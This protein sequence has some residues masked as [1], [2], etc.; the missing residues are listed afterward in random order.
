MIDPDFAALVD[1]KD[2]HVF[3]TPYE[4]DHLLYVTDVT[5]EGFTVRTDMAFEAVKGRQE[6]ELSGAFSWRVVARRK[7]IEGKRLEKVSIP[8]EPKLPS[9]G[10]DDPAVRDR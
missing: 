5:P 1:L 9:A 6:T 10:P 3:V 7:D 4:H 8:A 2:Y